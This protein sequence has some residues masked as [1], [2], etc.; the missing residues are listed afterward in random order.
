MENSKEM[1]GFYEQFLYIKKGLKKINN[2]KVD[3]ER[4]NTLNELKANGTTRLF[5]GFSSIFDDNIAAGIYLKRFY[6]LI[7]SK[8]H[9]KL[10]FDNIKHQI[11]LTSAAVS[12]EHPSLPYRIDF[13]L[14]GRRFN[15]Y[16]IKEKGVDDNNDEY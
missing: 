5:L 7:Q 10:K 1:I 4:F 15:M 9:Y 11:D 14:A 6:K 13:H 3:E 16:F 12:L 2:F 8:L